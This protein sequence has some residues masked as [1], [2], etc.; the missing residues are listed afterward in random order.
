[1]S[2]GLSQAEQIEAGT[3]VL[4]TLPAL[5]ER[6]MQ[7]TEQ[8][9][10]L[11]EQLAA[12]ATPPPTS[13]VVLAPPA[14]PSAPLTPAEMVSR[15]RDPSSSEFKQFA[16]L[17]GDDRTP[18]WNPQTE[19]IIN[20][21][22]DE[23]TWLDYSNVGSGAPPTLPSFEQWSREAYV[24]KLPKEALTAQ[25]W[26]LFCDWFGALVEVGIIKPYRPIPYQ[27]Q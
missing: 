18:Q 21:R 16:Y 12:A 14:T 22:T 11:Q 27:R 26:E 9:R 13:V 6:M 8:L 25:N 17:F 7:H 5:L 23:R 24:L 4:A 1:M 19:T 15:L 2:A 10:T 3:K 20:P